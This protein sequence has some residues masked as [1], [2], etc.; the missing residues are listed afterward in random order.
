MTGLGYALGAYYSLVNDN[1]HD[2]FTEYIPFAEDIVFFFEERQYRRRLP[3]LQESKWSI[4][5]ETGNNV[6]IPS[7]SGM[8]WRVAQEPHG[9][10]KTSGQ[11]GPHNSAIDVMEDPASPEG[12][13]KASGRPP[14]SDKAKVGEA[15]KPEPPKKTPPP[16]S[17]PPAGQSPTGTAAARPE[18]EA[19]AELKPPVQKKEARKGRQDVAVEGPK[20]ESRTPPI[21]PIKAPESGHP[22]IQDVVKIINNVITVVNAENATRKYGPALE[23]A[24]SEVAKIGD[25]IA[26]STEEVVQ[27]KL[28]ATHEE[29]DQAAKELVRRVEEEMADQEARW[30][31]DFETERKNMEHSFA[32][33][34]KT[35]LARSGEVYE[36]RLRNE[37][38]EQ[39]IHLKRHFAAK[40]KDLV[41]DERDGRLGKLGELSKSVN[42]LESLTTGWNNVV[43]TNLKT[44]RLHVAVE[45]V[46]SILDETDQPRPFV[47]ELAALR[48]TASDD[49]VVKAAIASINPAAYRYGLPSTAYLIDRFRRVASEVRKASLVP[50][51][52]GAASHAASLVLSKVLFRKEGPTAGDDVESILTRTET[53]LEEGDLDGAAREMNSMSGWA[54][55]LSK[56]WLAEVRKVLEAQQALDVS[57]HRSVSLRPPR[58]VVRTD[59]GHQV[60]AAEARLR[61]LQMDG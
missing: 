58:L 29:F 10:G 27:E 55:T 54:K 1:F 6:S 15:D 42:E 53:L 25:A 4:P 2:F 23:M 60:I 34:L 48:E 8:S 39:A 3:S 43:D 7:G 52:A 19:P 44:Q 51:Q 9:T 30:R 38:L 41:E 59:L 14:Q 26:S 47:R 18:G 28:K 20:G 24:R 45:A 56:D 32:E 33:K 22:I 13:S 40:V 35:E 5:R 49:P 50:E 17:I 31:D 12:R 37:L 46:R 57:G 21:E 61:S 11:P 16:T 36:R